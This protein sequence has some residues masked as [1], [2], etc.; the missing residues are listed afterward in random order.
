MHAKE[1][2]E[3]KSKNNQN[4]I[5]EEKNCTTNIMMN[6]SIAKLERDKSKLKDIEEIFVLR[7]KQQAARVKEKRK[8]PKS[9]C[10]R[11]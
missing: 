10:S 2:E 3:L 8:N 6:Q 1:I 11:N 4:I 5:D 7:A 9:S